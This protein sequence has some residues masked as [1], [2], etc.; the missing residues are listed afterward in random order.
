MILNHY[1]EVAGLSRR[2]V[3]STSES[4]PCLPKQLFPKFNGEVKASFFPL[5]FGA[6]FYK[7]EFLIKQVNYLFKQSSSMQRRGSF[8]EGESVVAT[9]IDVYHNQGLAAAVYFIIFIL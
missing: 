6:W 3:G 8:M 9:M 1:E 4:L 5:V 2:P 7:N